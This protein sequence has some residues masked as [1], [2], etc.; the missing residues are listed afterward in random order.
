MVVVKT[1]VPHFPT[2]SIQACPPKCYGFKLVI[3]SSFLWHIRT[4]GTV[5]LNVVSSV[6]NLLTKNVFNSFLT[7]QSIDRLTKH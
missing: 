2:D 7:R 4:Q 1:V 3:A 6:A 5:T